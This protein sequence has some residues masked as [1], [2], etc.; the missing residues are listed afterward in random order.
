MTSE[1]RLKHNK[2]LVILPLIISCV[3][4]YIQEGGDSYTISQLADWQHLLIGPSST[5][6]SWFCMSACLPAG[7]YCHA[8]SQAD[9]AWLP[10]KKRN[11]SND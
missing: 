9:W 5:M 3:F 11:G 6:C 4:L 2:N 1:I 7:K 8:P 10:T